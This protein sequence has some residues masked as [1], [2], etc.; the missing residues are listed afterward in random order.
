MSRGRAWGWAA[1]LREGATT[2]WRDWPADGSGEGEALGDDLPGAQQLALLRRLNVAADAAGRR[3]PL[4]TADRVLAAG[5]SGRGRGDLPV[6][7]ADEPERFGL[8][9]VDPDELPDDELL[10]VA[11]GLIA[12]DRRRDRRCRARGADAARPCPFRPPAVGAGVRRGRC[13][14][15]RRPRP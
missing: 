1:A 13:A 10:R 6:A 8:R 14:V 4:P 9:P 2:P 7:G 15:A 12:D 11:A 3:V 5:V